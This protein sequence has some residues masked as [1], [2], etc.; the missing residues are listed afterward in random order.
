MSRNTQN[1]TL[2]HHRRRLSPAVGGQ[3]RQ[4][5]LR[6]LGQLAALG[7]VL[8]LA[9]CSFKTPQSTLDPHGLVS[10]DEISLFYVTVW[11]SLFIFVTVGGTMAVAVWKFREKPGDED[12]PMP[13][14]GHGN[15]VVEIGLITASIALLVIVAV[16]TLKAI[17][18]TDAMPTDQPYWKPSLLGSWYQQAGGTLPDLAASEPLTIT[19]QGKQWWWAFDYP[20]F[21]VVT[22]NEFVIPAGK[23][24][25]FDLR[26]DNVIHSFWLPKIAGKVDAIP[27]RA[28]WMWMMADDGSAAKDYD[29]G[30][31]AADQYENGLYYGQC[32]QYCGESHA[33]MLF[34]TRVVSDADFVKWIEQ[35][36]RPVFPPGYQPPAAT[37]EPKKSPADLAKQAWTG[38]V[39][40]A[41]AKD[42]SVLATPEQRG[43]ALFFGR[44][45][46]L[47]CHTINGSPAQGTGGPNLSLVAT[48]TAIAAGVLDNLDNDGKGI[49][50]K[51]QAD[52]FFNWITHPYD[53]K[54][55]NLMWYG[56]NTGGK[57]KA[58]GLRDIVANNK[59]NGTPITDQDFH[60]IVAFLMTLK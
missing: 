60:D 6:G 34:R 3:S 31:V 13:E 27:G 21:G 20:Q 17:F 1:T 57:T 32:A 16:P 55:G 42:S 9:G 59:A 53:F 46:C 39:K 14:Q 24:V 41:A 45:S 29:H 56:A 54:P 37:T 30:T 36:Q 48:R 47:L 15:P 18:L 10:R 5:W 19:V 33:F 40:A 38:F 44:A 4:R 35:A 28:N 22:A 7:L 43:A 58:V 8:T 52:N 49:N 50:P 23:V 12:K 51:R 26:S 11:V 2:N 25:K